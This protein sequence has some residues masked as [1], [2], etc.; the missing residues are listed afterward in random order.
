MQDPYRDSVPHPR[1][2]DG[3]ISPGLEPGWDVL[4]GGLAGGAGMPELLL[5]DS[6]WDGV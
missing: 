2:L 4:G 6:C 5:A 1:T 3:D